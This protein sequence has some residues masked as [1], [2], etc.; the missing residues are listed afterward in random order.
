MEDFSALVMA[1]GA[2]LIGHKS[3]NVRLIE[4]G[5]FIVQYNL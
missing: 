4:P 3:F 1:D 5:H 2:E